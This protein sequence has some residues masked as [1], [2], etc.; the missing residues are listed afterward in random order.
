MGVVLGD[1]CCEFFRLVAIGLAIGVA[2][3]SIGLAS[4]FLVGWRAHAY[5][6]PMALCRWVFGR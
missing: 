3:H 5:E 6:M 2:I 4:K 1:D